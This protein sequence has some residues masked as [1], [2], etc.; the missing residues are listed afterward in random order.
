MR[1]I[2]FIIL[3]FVSLQTS[4]QTIDSCKFYRM[5]NDTLRH[6]LYVTNKKLVKVLFYTNICI[7]NH[8]QIKFLKGWINR[9]IK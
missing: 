5:Q 6:N 1:K 3:F 8:S 4:G 7:K 2:L 9:T